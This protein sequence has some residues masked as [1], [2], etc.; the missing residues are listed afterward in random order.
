MK[1]GK[2][3]WIPTE[4]Q[5]ELRIHEFYIATRRDNKKKLFSILEI[6]FFY[7][8]DVYEICTLI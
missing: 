6:I 5:N 7:F 3:Q 2:S 4:H 8:Y 1:I